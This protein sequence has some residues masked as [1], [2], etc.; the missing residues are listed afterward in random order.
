MSVASTEGKAVGEPPVGAAGTS[1]EEERELAAGLTE[2]EYQ[3]RPAREE[4]KETPP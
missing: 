4:P 3:L 1:V 2:L